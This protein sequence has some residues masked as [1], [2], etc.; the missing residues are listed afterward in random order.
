MSDFGDRNN[1]Q[2]A[3]TGAEVI[4]NLKSEI[5]LLRMQ[6]TAMAKALSALETRVEEIEPPWRKLLRTDDTMPHGNS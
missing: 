4:E 5:S 2:L 1:L 3:P 6:V